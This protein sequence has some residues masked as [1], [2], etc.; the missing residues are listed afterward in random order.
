ME[1]VGDE[2]WEIGQEMMLITKWKTGNPLQDF[3]IFKELGQFLGVAHIC[4]LLFKLE[5]SL[6]LCPLPERY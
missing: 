3:F 5:Q 4:A 6:V 1:D 2:Q